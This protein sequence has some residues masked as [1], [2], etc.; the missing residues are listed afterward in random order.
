LL[1]FWV[2][3]SRA[4][5]ESPLEYAKI[6]RQ[7]QQSWT[8]RGLYTGF[9]VTW[10][11]CLGLMTTY[12]IL[13]DSGRRHFPDAFKQPI[14]GPFLTSG[15]AATLAWWL[16]WP[17]EYMK[18]QV[19]GAY[20]EKMSTL[21]RMRLV[22]KERGGFLGLYRGILPGTIRSFMSNGTSMIV[23]VY[24]QRKVSEWGLRDK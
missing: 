13:V 20:G 2:S 8:F 5:I 14:M 23:M 3:S 7:T 17:L 15:I 16:V 19:Q 12:F 9:G 22:V 4:F 6:R 18:S 24:A 21:E 11:R 1:D 10:A